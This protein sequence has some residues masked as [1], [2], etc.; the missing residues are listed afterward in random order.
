MFEMWA[1]VQTEGERCAQLSRLTGRGP[2]HHILSSRSPC[3]VMCQLS[4]F[5]QG[6][7]FFSD[8]MFSLWLFSD[9]KFLFL[10]QAISREILGVHFKEM[11]TAVSRIYWFCLGGRLHWWVRT[12]SWVELQCCG[13]I[14]ML[15]TQKLT[16]L[17]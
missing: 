14:E 9:F 12:P 1:K 13:R 15:Q 5:L 11:K 4:T 3:K 8:W 10:L 2:T 7:A 17:S 16:V 6:R